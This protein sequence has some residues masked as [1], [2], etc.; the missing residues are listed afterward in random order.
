MKKKHIRINQKPK[1]INPKYIVFPRQS[2]SLIIFPSC[3]IHNL[4]TWSCSG[5]AVPKISTCRAPTNDP[6]FV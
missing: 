5:P 2:V 6:K 1:K 4:E 3:W